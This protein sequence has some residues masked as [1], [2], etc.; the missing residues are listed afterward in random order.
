[1]AIRERLRGDV[2]R[3]LPPIRFAELHVAD[4]VFVPVKPP[5]EGAMP[6]GVRFFMDV[7]GVWRLGAF[8]DHG[9]RVT[10]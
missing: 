6:L 5:P 8:A 10:P 3:T 4:A 2:D 1:V 7:D 9:D